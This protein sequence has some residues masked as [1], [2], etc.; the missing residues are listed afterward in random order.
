MNSGQDY[1]KTIGRLLRRAYLEITPASGIEDRLSVIP[2]RSYISITCSPVTGVEPTLELMER[3]SGNGWR[4]E[5]LAEAGV[6]G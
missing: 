5:L 3:L 2:R 1:R 6:A 4:Q